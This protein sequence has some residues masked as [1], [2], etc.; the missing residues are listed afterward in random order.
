MALVKSNRDITIIS[1]HGVDAL[2]KAF[3]VTEIPD[4][5]LGEALLLGAFRC[6]KDG[7]LIGI[8]GLVPMVSATPDAMD[9]EPPKPKKERKPATKE[10][11]KALIQN[12]VVNILSYND[13]KDVDERGLPRVVTVSRMVG[14]RAT[15]LDILAAVKRLQKQAEG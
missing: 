12:A 2:I 14:F 15:P 9:D 6:D 13:P 8:E 10:E 5:L 3:T 11:R 4:V 1:K 7:K